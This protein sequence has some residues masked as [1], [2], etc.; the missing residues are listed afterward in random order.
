MDDCIAVLL[1][2]VTDHFEGG[3]TVVDHIV[4]PA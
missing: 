4:D 3:L 1:R 2:S